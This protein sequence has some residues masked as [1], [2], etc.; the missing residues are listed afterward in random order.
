[1]MVV[2]LVWG[3]T[4]LFN[5]RRHVEHVAAATPAVVESFNGGAAADAFSGA[6]G[7]TTP[8]T[9]HRPLFTHD[10]KRH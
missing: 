2:R 4:S 1:M 6:D 7:R 9:E 3:S 8:Q 10:P 5:F